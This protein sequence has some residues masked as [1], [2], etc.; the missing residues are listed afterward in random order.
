MTGQVTPF[1]EARLN[2]EVRG[3][4]GASARVEVVL[5]TGFTGALT[6][7]ADLVAA[8]ALAPLSSTQVILADGSLVPANVFAAEVVWDHQSRRV[9]VHEAEGGPLL[10]MSLLHGHHLAMDVIDGGRLTITPLP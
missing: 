8:L 2:L 5:D 4:N 7:P 3:A 6:L 1:H 9:R 10:G